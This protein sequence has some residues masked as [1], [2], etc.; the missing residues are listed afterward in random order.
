MLTR[1]PVHQQGS[2]PAGG[3]LV[4]MNISNLTF[5]PEAA[6]PV[7]LGQADAFTDSSGFANFSSLIVSASPGDY[8]LHVSAPQYNQVPLHSRAPTCNAKHILQ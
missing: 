3:I 1:R 6:A 8:L 5:F 7:L 4:S 2:A